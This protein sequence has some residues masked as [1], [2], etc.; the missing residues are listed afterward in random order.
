VA[1]GRWYSRWLL[2]ERKGIHMMTTP[3]TTKGP[4][5]LTTI[6]WLKAILLGFCGGLIFLVAD[7]LLKGK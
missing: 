1:E 3:Q 5:R 7:I 4:I 2:G 6:D